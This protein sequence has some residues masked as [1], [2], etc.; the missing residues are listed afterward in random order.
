[1]EVISLD[2]LGTGLVLSKPENLK[3]APTSRFV[4]K[5]NSVGSW[6]EA[7]VSLLIIEHTQLIIKHTQFFSFTLFPF[8]SPWRWGGQRSPAGPSCARRT[9]R[10]SPRP[11]GTGERRV[12]VRLRSA[13]RSTASRSPRTSSGCCPRQ[14]PWSS[15]WSKVKQCHSVTHSLLNCYLVLLSVT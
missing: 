2:Q 4:L 14:L 15:L 5:W 13:A 3:R 9:L 8:C 12:G 7:A 1:M 6:A 10:P 11:P